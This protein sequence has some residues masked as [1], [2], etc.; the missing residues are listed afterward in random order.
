MRTFG[1]VVLVVGV[2]ALLAIPAS[3][4][5]RQRGRGGFGAGPGALGPAMLLAS[6]DVRKDLKVTDEQAE[7][8]KDIQQQM[9]AKGKEAFAEVQKLDESERQE[10][11]LEIFRKLNE[12][13]TQAVAK[14]LTPDQMKRLKQIQLQQQGAQALADPEVQKK[15]NLTDEQK[16]KVKTITEDSRKEMR[17]ITQAAQGDFQ[18]VREKMQSL[19]KETNEKVMAVL[20]DEQK[21]SWKDMN[22]EPF[23]G[24][25]N[26]GFGGRGG[27]GGRGGKPADKQNQ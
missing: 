11:R 6:E 22:G 9:G 27:R 19:R 13:S 23:K 10:K 20:T 4:Q 14:I 5:Q 17:E 16:E 3:S 24:Q 26:T 2:V 18:G 1:K 21:K 15:L 12:E 25:I 8:L 7:K